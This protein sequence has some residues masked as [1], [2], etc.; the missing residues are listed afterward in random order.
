MISE[1]VPRTLQEIFFLIGNNLRSSY[2]KEKK[3]ALALKTEINGF[4]IYV[5]C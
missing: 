3:N 5:L 2:S 1:L 4:S